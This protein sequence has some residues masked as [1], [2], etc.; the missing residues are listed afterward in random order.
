MPVTVSSF[1]LVSEALLFHARSLSLTL[2]RP[3]AATSAR[4][5]LIFV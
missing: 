2:A 3:I 4:R 1:S 5:D